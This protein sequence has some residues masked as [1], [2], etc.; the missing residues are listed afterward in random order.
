MATNLEQQIQAAQKRWQSLKQATTDSPTE[1]P[2]LQDQALT[3]LSI[4]LEELSVAAEEL[5]ATRQEVE[6]ERQRYQELFNFA[7]DGY[8]VTSIR[9]VIQEANHLAETMLNSD[10]DFLRDKPLLSFITK[11]DS[12]IFCTQLNQLAE[13]QDRVE[14]EE[15]DSTPVLRSWIKKQD[16]NSIGCCFL[17]DW[18]VHLKPLKKK[19][20]PA[21]LSTSIE[22]E[23]Q[24]KELRVFWLLRD[25]RAR[26]QAEEKIR[27]QAALLDIAR[28]AIWVQ[29]LE[30][31]ILF[32]N[33]GAEELYR[34]KRAEVLYKDARELIYSESSPQLTDIQDLVKSRGSWTGELEQISKTGKKILVESRWTLV[35]DRQE[36]PKSILIVNTDITE[37]KQLAAQFLH[38]Q[39]LENVGQLT[40]SIA[41]DLNK[42]LNPIL[43]ISQL[44]QLKLGDADESIQEYLKLQE[45]NARR[46]AALIRQ[47]LTCSQIA[48]GKKRRLQLRQLLSE[49]QLIVEAT[50]PKDITILSQVQPDLNRIWGNSTEIRQVLLNLCVNARDNMS[51][52]GKL[53]ISA[54]NFNVDRDYVQRHLEVKVGPY[55]VITVSDT[56]TGMAPEIMERIFDPFFT[57]K[58]VDQI[59][60][61]GLSTVLDIIKSHGGFIE[62]ASEVGKGSQ[63]KVFLPAVE[64]FQTEVNNQKLPRGNGELI[65]LV[66]N[67]ENICIATKATLEAYNYEVLT[68]RDGLE[69]IALYELNQER[70]RVVLMDLIMPDLDGLTAITRLREINPQV[71]II[72]VSGLADK[73]LIA[74]LEAGGINAFLP[75]PYSFKELLNTLAA[76]I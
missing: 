76:V 19:P 49:V 1:S 5:L 48:K 13:F 67:Q 11:A 31:K 60:G 28:D 74:K 47:M 66:D 62:V 36:N 40:K 39:P 3:E 59:K 63:F 75:K 64:A 18:E 20:F 38:L 17:Q 30:N 70:I 25:I 42:T 9:G 56:G 2:E 29:D 37:K 16:I 57:T 14:K 24:G 65:L 69:A 68:A 27:E 34:W 52:G 8:L 23:P 58:E 51:S 26:K 73:D 33:Q 35:R 10:R 43:T 21:A 71:K 45:A 55:V 7:P 22:Y 32:W 50:F 72:A 61:L 54:V 6:W 53:Q 4:A 41:Q 15:G 46:S 44:L 12:K